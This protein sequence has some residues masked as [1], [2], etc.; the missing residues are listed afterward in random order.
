MIKRFSKGYF[1]FNFNLTLVQSFDNTLACS[2]FWWN[3]FFVFIT[4]SGTVLFLGIF[5]SFSG[6]SLG[7]FHIGIHC[8]IQKTVHFS[9]CHPIIEPRNIHSPNIMLIHPN[10]IYR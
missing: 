7:H 2:L 1:I 5:V 4:L 10:M 9:F 3:V 6:Y 8:F